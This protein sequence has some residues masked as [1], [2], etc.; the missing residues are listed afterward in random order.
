MPDLAV[1]PNQDRG[2]SADDVA[3]H[4]RI[5]RDIDL[6]VPDIALS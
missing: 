6:V 4:R 1:T 2:R 5:K 3:L